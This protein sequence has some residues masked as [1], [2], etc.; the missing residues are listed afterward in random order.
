[1]S[2]YEV[3]LYDILKKTNKTV[4]EFEEEDWEFN[5]VNNKVT[6]TDSL[7]YSGLYHDLNDI[8]KQQILISIKEQLNENR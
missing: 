8:M 4:F 6:Y 2:K 1:M 3:E 7:G 5:I